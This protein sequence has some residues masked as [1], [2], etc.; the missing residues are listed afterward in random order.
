MFY[1]LISL[2]QKEIKMSSTVE[3]VQLVVPPWPEKG[4]QSVVSVLKT[5]LY[6]TIIIYPT[7]CEEM[8]LYAKKV[9]VTKGAIYD[10]LKGAMRVPYWYGR[11]FK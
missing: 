9:P 6:C 3:V 5:V 11:P 8:K 4:L 2:R 1:L 7:C 10:T